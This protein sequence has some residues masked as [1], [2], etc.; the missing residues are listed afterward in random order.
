M[1]EGLHSVSRNA[2][3]LI[4]EHLDARACVAL[5]RTC[6]AVKN[7]VDENQNTALKIRLHL[8]ALTETEDLGQVISPNTLVKLPVA[9][10][11]MW[12]DNILWFIFRINSSSVRIES[13]DDFLGHIS[14]GEGGRF[15]QDT[16]TND[17]VFCNN[18]YGT[19]LHHCYKTNF[20]TKPTTYTFYECSPGE[21][22]VDQIDRISE[23]LPGFIKNYKL[24][25]FPF[26][27]KGRY[28]ITKDDAG[29]HRGTC[30]CITFNAFGIAGVKNIQTNLER[31]IRA[32]P[33]RS[34]VYGRGKKRTS[35]CLDEPPLHPISA[36]VRSFK[37]QHTRVVKT[38]EDTGG[39][40][41]RNKV[42]DRK[43][44]KRHKSHGG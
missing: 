38:W 30:E 24:I 36:V 23:L 26:W 33:R 22:K 9:T 6:H 1:E 15:Y 34:F 42:L 43:F 3:S 35:T 37:T 44:L 25:D 11:N 28:Y 5:R 2:F 21:H 16:V 29:M 20:P 12:M 7:L 32:E 40:I 39:S 4:A 17:I 19:H 10:A 27:P 18:Y 8:I 31:M 13:L 41:K 14:G